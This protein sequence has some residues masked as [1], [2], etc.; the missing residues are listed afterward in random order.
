[1]VGVIY[2]I[3]RTTDDGLK[4]LIYIGKTK[5]PKEKRWEEHDKTANN[6]IMSHDDSNHH[7]CGSQYVLTKANKMVNND[8]ITRSIID[9]CETEENLKE[10]EQLW[11]DY[12]TDKSDEYIVMN[13]VNPYGGDLRRK[14]ANWGYRKLYNHI[15][16][17]CILEC[18]YKELPNEFII[19]SKFDL[20]NDDTKIC[21][22][23]H[24]LKKEYY[25]VIHRKTGRTFVVGSGCVDKF[26]IILPENM[27]KSLNTNK[28]VEILQ[29]SLNSVYANFD[30]INNDNR[31]N[32]EQMINMS[33][34]NFR[35]DLEII[36]N[37]ELQV[38]KKIFEEFNSIKLN[39]KTHNKITDFLSILDRE[40]ERRAEIQKTRAEYEKRTAEYKKRQE[41]EAEKRRTENQK[42]QEVEAARIAAA[43]A[44]EARWKKVELERMKKTAEIVDMNS[45]NI[46]RARQSQTRREKFKEDERAQKIY[47]EKKRKLNLI[48]SV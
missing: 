14:S 15:H 5:R 46:E 13:I 3:S 27:E 10:K 39:E 36:S 44:S 29:S 4:T 20:C 41:V 8:A 40:V 16:R 23:G 19:T 33:I 37:E 31:L 45:V 11:I 1:M 6:F 34:K 38:I 2:K 7:N 26:K 42:R 9:K 48:H 35:Y 32:Q 47:D 22:C 17:I 24:H 43:A 21:T 12:Y 25:I 28:W 30:E 18:T